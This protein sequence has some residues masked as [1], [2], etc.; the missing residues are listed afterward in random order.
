M[1]RY[2]KDSENRAVTETN[3]YKSKEWKKLRKLK[4]QK[5]PL[6]EECLKCGII[7]PV[8]CVHHKIWL[9]QKNITDPS[10]T[11]NI[12]NLQSLCYECHN[13]IHARS[14]H[15]RYI[16]DADGETVDYLDD[17]TEETINIYHNGGY[18]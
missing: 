1:K 16:I 14:S 12:N 6:C 2:C 3:F 4:I 18:R 8:D 11:L 17:G 9:T 15:P 5:D 13:R 10:V 7:T